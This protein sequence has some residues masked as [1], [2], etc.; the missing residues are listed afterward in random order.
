MGQH[1]RTFLLTLKCAPVC[2]ADVLELRE[3]G[4]TGPWR[5]M[6]QSLLSETRWVEDFG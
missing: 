4:R 6:D 2:P 3:S 1:S 5:T